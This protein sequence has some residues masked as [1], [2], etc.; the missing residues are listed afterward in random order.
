MADSTVIDGW[1][2]VYR[3]KKLWWASSDYFTARMGLAVTY[4]YAKTIC[5]VGY[6]IPSLS[7]FLLMP[8]EVRG[9]CFN[10]LYWASDEY[11]L[12]GGS[13]WMQ[14]PRSGERKAGPEF[15]EARVIYCK[16]AV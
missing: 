7:D 2:E 12:I 11:D 13:R 9:E 6:R 15:R 10:V 1:E 8:A 5:P 14:N 4:D 3:G 16:D